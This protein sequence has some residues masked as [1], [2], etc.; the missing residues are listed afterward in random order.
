MFVLSEIK[1]RLAKKIS[2]SILLASLFILPI[3]CFEGFPIFGPP[4][5]GTD[6]VQNEWTWHDV[7][8]SVCR[9]GSPTGIGLRVQDPKRLAIYL[10]GGGACFNDLTC[11]SNPSSFNEDDL[12]DLED[13]QFGIFDFSR[14][15]NPIRDWSVMFVPYC[16][17][18]VHLGTRYQGVALGVDE[19]QAF[20]GSYNFEK[21]LTF[22]KPYFD[23]NEVEEILLFGSSA[24]GYAV[25]THFM[26]VKRFFPN[27]KL[28]VIDDSGPIFEDLQ[29]FSP[30]LQ[31]GFAA[32]YGLQPPQGFFDANTLNDGI[33]SHIY[34]YSSDRFP[35]VNFGFISSLEDR[36]MRYFLSFGYDNCNGAPNNQLPAEVFRTS[37]LRLRD[38]YL[39]PETRWSTYFIDD[40]S[41]TQ[42]SDNEP[43]YEHEADGMKMYEWLARLLNG[44][45]SIHVSSE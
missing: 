40:D 20:V 3:S 19:P 26:K 27:A 35:D 7:E 22:I 21:A 29:A 9:D 11:A 1:I 4:L 44:E 15:E 34:R 14:P 2:L 23:Q 5:S 43:F 28:T 41:H 25:Y 10:N 17:G 24:G 45:E 6:V 39:I 13:S 8:G 12:F 33:L 38:T 16:T 37:L 36:T 18:D 30:C 31:I 42:L 32:I